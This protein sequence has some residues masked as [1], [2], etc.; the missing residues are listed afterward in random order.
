MSESVPGMC[1]HV[2]L[3]KRVSQRRQTRLFQFRV[4]RLRCNE[5]GDVEV[6]VLPQREEILIGR[7]G[8][9]RELAL[10]PTSAYE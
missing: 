7:L 9:S 8:V 10:Y 6:G 5:D 2:R 3:H 1:A 4:L